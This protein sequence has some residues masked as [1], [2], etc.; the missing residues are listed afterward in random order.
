MKFLIRGVILIVIIGANRVGAINFENNLKKFGVDIKKIEAKK[1]ISRYEATWLANFLNCFECFNPPQTY[2]DT[3]TSSWWEKF[4]SKPGNYFNDITYLQAYFRGTNYFWCVAKAAEDD[5]VNWY[6]PSNWACG[7]EFCGG[8]ILNEWELLQIIFN[9]VMP[10]NLDK[11]LVNWQDVFSWANENPNLVPKYL[12]DQ[13]TNS[14]QK[15]N[16]KACPLQSMDEARAYSI[17]C[18]WNPDKCWNKALS[19]LPRGHWALGNFLLLEKIGGVDKQDFENFNPSN[20]VSGRKLIRRFKKADHLVRCEIDIDYDK[21]WVLNPDDNCLYTPNANQ[22]DCDGD[23]IGDRC[24]EDLDGD[25]IPNSKKMVDDFGRVIPKYWLSSQDKD[26]CVSSLKA[27]K[28]LWAPLAG[29]NSLNVKFDLQ[30]IWT[31]RVVMDFDDWNIEYNF[32]SLK[33]SHMYKVWDFVPQAYNNLNPAIRSSLQVQVLPQFDGDIGS[34]ILRVKPLQGYVGE[35]FKFFTILDGIK[36][37]DITYILRDFG[38]FKVANSSLSLNKFYEKP[39]RYQVI[40]TILLKDGGEIKS[41]VWVWV[42]QKLDNS[43]WIFMDVEPLGGKIGTIFEF[44]LVPFFKPE[45]IKQVKWNFGDGSQLLTTVLDAKHIYNYGWSYPVRAEVLLKDWSK[46]Y[47]SLTV[48][49]E[50]SSVCIEAKDSLKCDMD[51]DWIPDMCDDDIDGDGIPN[52][53]NILAGEATDCRITQDVINQDV[54]S[55]E[56]LYAQKGQQ[57]DNCPFE[58]NQDQLDLNGNGIGD[59]CDVEQPESNW[60]WATQV[61]EGFNCY[62]KCESVS[63]IWPGSKIR[64]VLVDKNNSIVQ[65]ISNPIDISWDLIK[66]LLFK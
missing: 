43:K 56:I 6:A 52:L 42:N 33:F 11:F 63:P 12:L 29:Y 18:S 10:Y 38:D 61:E 8:N 45:L 36:K 31:W 37:D 3:H 54:L 7:W 47:P 13:I 30:K 58:V 59:K 28:L 62:G 20:S 50:G 16:N 17:Y 23:G 14:F 65:V 25:G 1:G 48:W 49:V 9:I 40:Q 44:K 2:I 66:K 57:I 53:P 41:N 21:D 60:N 39:G 5:I 26:L 55:E 22:F 32:D 4:K 46:L 64:A 24:D 51:K 27:L 15:C 19:M 34:W 35:V